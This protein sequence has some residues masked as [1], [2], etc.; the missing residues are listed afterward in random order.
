MS[1]R[2]SI[3]DEIYVIVRE[4][5]GLVGLPRSGAPDEAMEGKAPK[6]LVLGGLGVPH[7]HPSELRGQPMV[8]PAPEGK[9]DQHR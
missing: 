9:V 3:R 7:N 2:S 6:G 5:S 1:Y 4:E 8:G